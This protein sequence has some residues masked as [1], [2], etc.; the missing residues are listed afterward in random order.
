MF[1]LLFLHL[2]IECS[3]VT[4]SI[5]TIQPLFCDMTKCVELMGENLSCYSIRAVV[6]FEPFCPVDSSALY[7]FYCI[8]SVLMNNIHSFK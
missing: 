5:A 6:L 8:V 7:C 3:D 1:V 4:E 2:Y